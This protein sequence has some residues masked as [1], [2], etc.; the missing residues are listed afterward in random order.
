MTDA[1][2]SVAGLPA[3]RAEIMIPYTGTWVAD[4]DLD[5]EPQLSGAV[6]VVLG[7]L[8][9]NGTVAA[10]STGG[11][12]LSGKVRVVGG[13]G[14]WGKE[15]GGRGYHND[16]GVKRSLVATDVA[17]EVGEQLTVDASVDGSDG[18]DFVRVAG[19]A[20]RIFRQVFP[21][22]TWWVDTAGKSFVGPRPSTEITAEHEVLDADSRNLT[23][24][25]AT[26]HPEAIVPGGIIT[27]RLREPLH[28]RDVMHVAGASEAR[29][30]VWGTKVATTTP[31]NRIH[32]AIS[33]IALEAFPR[34]PYA[35][36][37][38]YRVV[39]LSGDRLVLQVVK[40]APGLPDILPISIWPGAAGV[41]FDCAAGCTV[42]VAFIEG[43]PSLPVV[44]AFEPEGGPKFK[45]V[46][47]S[48]DV[49]GIADPLFPGIFNPI[50][51]GDGAARVVRH[52]DIVSV[53]TAAGTIQITGTTVGTGLSKVST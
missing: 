35:F 52:G 1:F 32:S 20:S 37:Y 7:T 26:E 47:L 14:G 28:I 17:T 25:I 39:Q 3:V 9:L 29:S 45:P 24:V 48:A 50:K 30:L 33:R 18:P 42:L 15:L 34:A 53:G 13:A 23:A 44:V 31:G 46:N 22:A 41:S 51:L 6:E 40:R 16:A 4:L 38:R 21:D 43:D 36:L 11:F 8:R 49:T 5:V 19:P 2:L 27:K 10:A 12:Q